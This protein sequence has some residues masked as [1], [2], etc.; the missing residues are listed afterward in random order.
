MEE[1]SEMSDAN[2]IME[3]INVVTSDITLTSGIQ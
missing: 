2:N 1:K 3:V